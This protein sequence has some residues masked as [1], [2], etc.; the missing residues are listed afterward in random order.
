MTREEALKLLIEDWAHCGKPD[1]GTCQERQEAIAAL[2]FP[3]ACGGRPVI[4]SRPCVAFIGYHHQGLA[5][6]VLD[7][8]LHPGSHKT[9]ICLSFKPGW[10][11]AGEYRRAMVI[12]L[13]EGDAE[14]PIL[15]AEEVT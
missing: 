15:P 6:I 14:M 13:D 7:D 12:V 2:S 11:G 1:C 5:Y 9:S 8:A 3:C 4:E 10:T